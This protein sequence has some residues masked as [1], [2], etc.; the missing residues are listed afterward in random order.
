LDII[1]AHEKQQN[2][3]DAVRG[4]KRDTQEQDDEDQ[5]ASVL[6]RVKRQ[7]SRVAST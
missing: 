2:I 3:L 5:L 6:Q 7:K 4:K 1:N